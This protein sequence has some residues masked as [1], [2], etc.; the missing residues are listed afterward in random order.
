[1]LNITYRYGM[2]M[3]CTTCGLPEE[4]CCCEILST[5]QTVLTV[6]LDKRRYGKMVTLISGFEPSYNM[7]DLAS[8]LKSTCAAGGTIKHGII[9]IQGDHVN[10]VVRILEDKGFSVSKLK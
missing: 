5:E 4:I 9:E 8:E 2:H 3:I 7:S 6:K 10:V 1:M